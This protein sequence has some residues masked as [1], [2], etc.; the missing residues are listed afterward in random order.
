[1]ADCFGAFDIPPNIVF[2]E[3]FLQL[4]VADKD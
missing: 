2:E 1:M 3:E 4:V